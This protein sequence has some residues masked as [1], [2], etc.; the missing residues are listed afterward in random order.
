YVVH[1]IHGI[2]KCV[3]LEKLKFSDYEKDYFII[4]YANGDRLYLPTEQTDTISAFYAGEKE[5]KLNKLGGVE[6]AKIKEKVYKNVKQIA[7]DLLELYAKREKTMGN[8]YVK[9]DY[10]MEMFETAFPFEETADQLQAIND[11]KTDMESKKIMDRLVCGDVGYGKTEVALRAIYKAVL[12][13]KQVAFLCPTTIL[14]EQHYK[15]CQSRF[16]GF[17]VKVARFNR[18]VKKA[19]QDEVVKGLADGSINVVCGTHKLLND[20]LKFKNLTLLVLDEEQ[21]FGV[22][23]KEKIKNMKNNIDVL[24]LSA[25]PIPRTLH[26]SLSGIRDIS[27]IDTPPKE[28]LPIQTFVTQYT[29][30]LVERACNQELSRGG[31]VLVIFNR[32]DK[33]YDFANKMKKMLPN[34][35][36]GVAHGRL[37]QKLLEDAIMKLYNHKYQILVATTLIENGI[38]L[39]SAN[40]LIV[41]DADKLGLSQLYQIRGRIGRSNKTAYAYLTFNANKQLTNTAYQRL[42]AIMEHTALGSGF[43]IAMA[44]LE[45]RG[46]GNVLGKEQH[47]NMAKVGYDLY[48]K[49]LNMALKE[50]KGE[51]SEDK[52]DMKLDINISAY[53]DENYITNEDDRIKVYGQISLLNSQQQ[54][55]NLKTDLTCVYGKMPTELD[56][57]MKIALIKNLATNQNIKRIIINQNACKVYFYDNKDIIFSEFLSVN[58]KMEQVLE[59][60]SSKATL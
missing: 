15:T 5:P 31:Q 26:M 57:L 18:L 59:F 41:V 55:Q 43:K 46:A 58:D 52:K 23:D 35:N 30:D 47:G 45:I 39:P 32:I 8:V 51:K 14:A 13:G 16:N 27:I 48:Y 44:D 7:F 10:L 6:F 49:L 50:I 60:L 36:I 12:S 34:V 17:M 1:N 22:E 11:I 53:I 29:E 28:R 54:L 21:R 2:G 56:N 42:T 33:I 37:S 38:D 9:D 19:E 20:K 25:T 3:G 4:E 24:S 40:T